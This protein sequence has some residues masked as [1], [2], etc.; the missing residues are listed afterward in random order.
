VIGLGRGSGGQ[1]EEVER[2]ERMGKERDVG[3]DECQ[4]KVGK[5]GSI[6]LSGAVAQGGTEG[7]M[8]PIV[9][10]HARVIN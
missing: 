4:R 3:K 10:T 6:R 2:R 7:K 8:G 1:M 9:K 5:G